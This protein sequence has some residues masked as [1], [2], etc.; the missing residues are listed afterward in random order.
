MAWLELRVQANLET[1]AQVEEA[2][3][4]A[5]ALS[6]TTLD[7]ADSPIFEPDPD[8]PP[9][10]PDPQLVGLFDAN[11][12]KTAVEL[13]VKATID[14]PMVWEILE[15]RCWETEWARH[16]KPMHFGDNF[17]VYSQ[18]IEEAGAQTLLLDPGLAFGT[19]TH[20]TTA[21]CLE[22]LVG[23]S[24]E[25]QTLL[26]FGC[27]TGVLGIAGLLRG[28][29]FCH[30]TD[31]DPQALIATKNNLKKNGIDTERFR[32]HRAPMDSRPLQVD[33]LLANILSE[34]LIELAPQLCES[35]K[36]GGQIC[37]SGI[38]IDQADAVLGTYQ[39]LMDDLTVTYRDDWC[40]I[41]GRRGTSAR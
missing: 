15:D 21:L 41:S 25:H 31:I 10:W 14:A 33:I 17:W 28:A 23:Q 7:A 26:D 20:A 8:N 18:A 6:V 13:L 1:H 9:I 29:D 37:L 16:F 11:A 35:L 5:G 22:W 12:E 2:L 39:Q 40:C 4:A 36:P 32:L 19:G 34:P 38:L 3:F 24:I 30:F 27:G